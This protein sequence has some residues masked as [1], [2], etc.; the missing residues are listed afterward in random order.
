MTPITCQSCG[1]ANETTRVFC[2]Q[3]GVRLDKPA[4]PTAPAPVARTRPNLAKSTAQK[5]P[6]F[7][8]FS[9]VFSLISSSIFAALLAAIILSLRPPVDI[10]TQEGANAAQAAAV[11]ERLSQAA[12]AVQAD[13][14][15]ASPRQFIATSEEI[16]SFLASRVSIRQAGAS[17]TASEA[18]P[19]ITL[20]NQSFILG[21]QINLSKLEII[22]Q[23]RYRVAGSPGHLTLQIVNNQIGSLPLPEFLGNLLMGWTKG[24][25]QAFS[26]QLGQIQTAENVHIGS[27]NVQIIWKAEP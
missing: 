27:G 15:E 25:G 10:P 14:L 22:S 2:H 3:C 7:D 5:K 24:V 1:F 21:M 11:Q 9:V 19:F 18:H 20:E 16:N 8:P 23:R 26:S 12:Q 17:S 13:D 4:V 6:L